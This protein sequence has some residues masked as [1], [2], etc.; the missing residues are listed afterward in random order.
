M[1]WGL[2]LYTEYIFQNNTLAQEKTC[3]YFKTWTVINNYKKSYF[4]IALDFLFMGLPTV[5]NLFFLFLNHRGISRCILQVLHHWQEQDPPQIGASPGSLMGCIPFWNITAVSY[6]PHFCSEIL[7]PNFVTRL[8]F[9]V[10]EFGY[11]YFPSEC[12]SY[13]P[14]GEVSQIEVCNMGFTIFVSLQ[15]KPSSHAKCVQRQQWPMQNF[16]FCDEK[17]TFLAGVSLCCIYR[18]MLSSIISKPGL[19]SVIPR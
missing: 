15:L 5:Q 6:N 8:Y 18:A 13:Y 4:A 12:L 10:L 16:S 17:Q 19:K 9:L 7:W 1:F 3:L 14:T 11:R 2:R